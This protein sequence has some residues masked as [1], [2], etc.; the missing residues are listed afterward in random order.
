MS[1][2]DDLLSGETEAFGGGEVFALPGHLYAVYLP[3]ATPAGVLVVPPDLING[4]GMIRA[5]GEF[6]GDPLMVATKTMDYSW[7]T[8][9]RCPTGIGWCWLR[10]WMRRGPHQQWRITTPR[11]TESPSTAK[12][13]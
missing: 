4:V 1:P 3:A 10:G 6:A 7:A 12:T 13:L 11:S 5:L 9:R 2:A 8:H